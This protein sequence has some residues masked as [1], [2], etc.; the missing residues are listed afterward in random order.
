MT[1]FL[2]QF[3]YLSV[4]NFETILGSFLMILMSRLADLKP[5]LPQQTS[6]QNHLSGR[7]RGEVDHSVS[8]HR[9]YLK[10]TIPLQVAFQK[11]HPGKTQGKVYQSLPEHQEYLKPTITLQKGAHKHFPRRTQG[12]VLRGPVLL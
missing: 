1:S 8:D 12:N 6:S 9:E 5:T 3:C 2:H 10:P 7:T 4:I 11:D